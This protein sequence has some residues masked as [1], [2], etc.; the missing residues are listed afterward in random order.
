MIHPRSIMI[1]PCLAYVEIGSVVIG[2]H[3]ANI[4][5]GP[6]VIGACLANIMVG[7]IVIRARLANIVIGPIIIGARLANIVVGPIIIGAHLANIVVGPIIIG[8]CLA[9][10]V[11][12]S[13]IIRARLMRMLRFAAM[14]SG[15]GVRRMLMHRGVQ[16]TFGA[17]VRHM[18]MLVPRRCRAMMDMWRVMPMPMVPRGRTPIRHKAQS[19][20]CRYGKNSYTGLRIAIHG[21]AVRI[22][23]NRETICIVAGTRPRYRGTNPGRGDRHTCIHS[24]IYHTRTQHN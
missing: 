11:V 19:R 17:M 8:T 2:A 21:A 13:V 15:G 22:A 3:L 10:I 12:G 1:G 24:G 18:P 9:N 7:S 23:I 5:V 14:S 20:Q 16:A 6:I 4:V